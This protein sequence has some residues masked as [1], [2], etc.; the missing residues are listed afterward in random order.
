MT[1][2]VMVPVWL[3]KVRRSWLEDV[4]GDDIRSCLSAPTMDHF[5][6]PDYEK[7]TLWDQEDVPTARV[8]GG[9]EGVCRG[10]GG[11]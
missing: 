4:V 6:P 5:S 3:V 9:V 11:G 1:V 8:S 7:D 2:I 10:G